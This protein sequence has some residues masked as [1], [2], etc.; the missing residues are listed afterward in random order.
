MLRRV[1]RAE[2]NGFEYTP[3]RGCA[4]AEE[5]TE[6]YINSQHAPAITG[7][8]HLPIFFTCGLLIAATTQISRD[9][10][11]SGATV[12]TASLA[13]SVARRSHNPKVVSSILTARSGWHCCFFMNACVSPDAPI[14]KKRQGHVLHVFFSV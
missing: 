7:F 13:Q 9:D 5:C 8:F 14:Q 1:E 12:D 2:Q 11:P 4:H 6:S 3:A 10:R